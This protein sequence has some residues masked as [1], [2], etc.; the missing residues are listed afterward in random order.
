MD[1]ITVAIIGLVGS[2]IGSLTG[3][4]VNS[5]MVQYR[6]EQL[7]RQVEKHNELID[8]TYKLEAAIELIDEKLR[9]ANREIQELEQ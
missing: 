9:E 2:A 5:K 6:I 1:A 7:E 3:I 8:R 4:I